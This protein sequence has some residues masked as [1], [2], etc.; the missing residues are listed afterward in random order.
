VLQYIAHR[1][2]KLRVQEK[3]AVNQEAFRWSSWEAVFALDVVM[4]SKGERSEIL[5]A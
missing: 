2:V 3:K 1:Y 4:F 5:E